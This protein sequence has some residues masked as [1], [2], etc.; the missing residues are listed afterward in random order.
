MQEPTETPIDDI[1]SSSYHAALLVSFQSKSKY[2]PL[3]QELKHSRQVTIKLNPSIYK[4][5][6]QFRDSLCLLA[7][8]DLAYKEFCLLAYG[9]SMLFYSR[10]DK[11]KHIITIRLLNEQDYKQQLSKDFKELNKKRFD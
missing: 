4:H 8:Q 2:L 5:H 9:E 3:W 6:K 11:E 1:A 7:K 10:Y